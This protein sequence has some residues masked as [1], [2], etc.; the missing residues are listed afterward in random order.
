MPSKRIYRW[1]NV[2]AL[3]I[4]LVVL[5]HFVTQYAGSSELCKTLFFII[6]TFH[7]PAFIFVSG[8]FS[9]SSLKN[10]SIKINR[11][12]TF[13]LLYVS[14][15]AVIWGVQKAFGENVQFRLFYEAGIPWYM[16]AMAVFIS[17][18]YITD[19]IDPKFLIA[20]S[21]VIALIAGYDDDVN[22]FL[23]LSRLLVFYPVFLLGYYA[24]GEKIADLAGRKSI[25]CISML[26]LAA[27]IAAMILLTDRLYALNLGSII[28][29]RHP[30]SSLRY[31][32]YGAAFRLCWYILSGALSFAL[33][34]AVPGT[35]NFLSYLGADTLPIYFLHRPLLYIYMLAD[36]NAALAAAMGGK[37]IFLYLFFS[38]PLTLLLS[39]K[40]IGKASDALM[41][42]RYT[43]IM[44]KTTSTEDKI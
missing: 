25:K 11:V 40:P 36:T 22:D 42:C 19:K 14:L 27:F 26:L 23:C 38:V 21:L 37:F 41:K 4:Y 29:A 6:Y 34:S 30:Y 5:G 10:N 33:F 31:P 3:L 17:L 8:L 24:D 39:V 12:I 28:T 7:M 32:A 9:K 1:D 35:K 18:T 15:K 20:I 44:K 43:K 13:L 2:K 16:L